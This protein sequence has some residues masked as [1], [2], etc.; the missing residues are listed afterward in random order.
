[1]AIE[2]RNIIMSTSVMCAITN[3]EKDQILLV[4]KLRPV[5]DHKKY[6]MPSGIVRDDEYPARAAC[7]ILEEFTGVKTNEPDWKYELQF[8]TTNNQRRL[9]VYSMFST[10]ILL[11]VL[12]NTSEKLIR[13]PIS[14]MWNYPLIA[15]LR[16]I[17]PLVVDDRLTKPIILTRS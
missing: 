11:K 15:S 14:T 10:D 4:E 17:I 8:I 16:Y 7:R 2:E 12:P 6:N 5:Q 13:L 3:N 9:I 1:M